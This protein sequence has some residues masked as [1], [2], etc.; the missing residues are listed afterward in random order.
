MEYNFI[1]T[2]SEVIEYLEEKIKDNLAYDDELELYEDYKW[3]GTINTGR[4]TYQLLKRE[5]E[6]NLFY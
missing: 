3:N 4:Y 5:I 6:N 2:S 1:I